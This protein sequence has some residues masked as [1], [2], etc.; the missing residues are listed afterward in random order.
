MPTLV[1]PPLR[2]FPFKRSTHNGRFTIA[3][4]DQPCC[5]CTVCIG[6]LAQ[7]TMEGRAAMQ[8]DYQTYVLPFCCAIVELDVIRLMYALHKMSTI[9][10]LI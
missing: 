2:G 4:P 1:W 6:S 3:Q 10:D 7:G 5:C 9:N 8:L